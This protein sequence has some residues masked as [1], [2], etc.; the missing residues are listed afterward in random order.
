M[1]EMKDKEEVSTVIS[2]PHNNLKPILPEKILLI[3]YHR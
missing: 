2:S 1:Y 3:F